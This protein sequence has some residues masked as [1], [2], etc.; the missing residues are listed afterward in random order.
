MVVQD[1][2]TSLNVPYEFKVLFCTVNY[3]LPVTLTG[4]TDVR[5]YVLYQYNVNIVNTVFY[6]TT[7]NVT[8]PNAYSIEIVLIKIETGIFSFDF[9][10]CFVQ[11]TDD[12]LEE[13]GETVTVFYFIGETVIQSV[14]SSNFSVHVNVTETNL[15]ASSIAIITHAVDAG[16]Q[17]NNL[18]ME[19]SNFSITSNRTTPPA[20][21][22]FAFGF[23]LINIYFI[24]NTFNILYRGYAINAIDAS[25][26]Y[27]SNNTIFPGTNGLTDGTMFTLPTF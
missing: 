24:N 1:V 25:I 7:L 12:R 21:G 27:L 10:S 5:Q 8:V 2:P 15:N 19:N 16:V 11:Y 26:A 13:G 3:T 23:S 17:K 14:N 4:S 6:G 20:S 9:S 22:V 18:I